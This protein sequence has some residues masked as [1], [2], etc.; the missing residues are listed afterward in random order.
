MQAGPMGDAAASGGLPW[1]QPFPDGRG[2]GSVGCHATR[3]EVPA[4][5]LSEASDDEVASPPPAEGG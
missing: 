2:A 3:F 4:K 5:F 1:L